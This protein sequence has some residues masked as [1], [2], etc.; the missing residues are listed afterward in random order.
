MG[1]VEAG[2]N[3]LEIPVILCC[4]VAGCCVVLLVMA[5]CA[6]DVV[7]VG[8]NVVTFLVTDVTG[9]GDE[10]FVFGVVIFTL[11]NDATGVEVDNFVD[12]A[13]DEE[14]V[15]FIVA[16]VVGTMDGADTAVVAFPLID[17]E[18]LDSL[19]GLLVGKVVVAAVVVEGTFVV[20]VSDTLEL[21]PVSDQMFKIFF[22]QTKFILILSFLLSSI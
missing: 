17:T 2:F 3:E 11:V 14:L 16:G 18:A 4:C 15:D 7:I 22:F 13:L 20:V 10:A 6:A 21:F 8:F 5:V 1:K 9:D 12:V 19:V